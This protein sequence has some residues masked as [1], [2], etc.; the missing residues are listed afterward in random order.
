VAEREVQ[1][2]SANKEGT[3]G[4]EG[5][6]NRLRKASSGRIRNKTKKMILYNLLTSKKNKVIVIKQIKFLLGTLL[7]KVLIIDHC[8]SSKK[9]FID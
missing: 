7:N 2:A 5:L 4:F 9:N 1:K 6:Q 3:N 8:I